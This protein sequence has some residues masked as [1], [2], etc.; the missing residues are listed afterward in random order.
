MRS[1]DVHWLRVKFEPNFAVG[2]SRNRGL[3][4]LVHIGICVFLCLC[5][6]Q[7]YSQTKTFVRTFVA[8]FHASH[9]R[10]MHWGVHLACPHKHY[11]SVL[12]FSR[13]PSLRRHSLPLPF[14]V[15]QFSS[16]AVMAVI[17]QIKGRS[18][19]PSTVILGEIHFFEWTKI[20]HELVEH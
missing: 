17:T 13:S 4:Q 12:S 6:W 2:I 15:S 9:K 11:Q 19:L 8:Q 18:P 3:I 14:L 1:S 20:T 5:V 7:P 10:G 16:V